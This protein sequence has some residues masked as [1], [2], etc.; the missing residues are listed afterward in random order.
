M[1]DNTKYN[2]VGTFVDPA[3]ANFGAAGNNFVDCFPDMLLVAV[4]KDQRI[5]SIGGDQYFFDFRSTGER[6]VKQLNGQDIASLFKNKRRSGRFKATIFK[7]FS[8][9]ADTRV[10]KENKAL[11]NHVFAAAGTLW[12]LVLPAFFVKNCP[13]NLFCF[14]LFH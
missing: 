8:A 11:I 2:M 5:G 7:Q 9:T 12:L 3:A 6:L 1:R 13:Q 14:F 10:V 4:G